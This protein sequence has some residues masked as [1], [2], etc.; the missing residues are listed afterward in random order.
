MSLVHKAWLGLGG[1]IGVPVQSMAEALQALD[2][3]VR[4]AVQRH[5]QGCGGRDGDSGYPPA[6]VLRFDDETRPYR[7]LGAQPA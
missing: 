6:A 5:D 2:R 4:A 1:N 3:R 7:R